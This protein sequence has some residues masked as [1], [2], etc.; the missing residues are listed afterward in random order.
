MLSKCDEISYQLTTHGSPSVKQS[1]LRSLPE[2]SRKFKQQY[3]FFVRAC[4]LF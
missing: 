2:F 1:P 4:R 3:D